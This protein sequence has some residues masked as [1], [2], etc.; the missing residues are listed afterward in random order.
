MPSKSEW[1]RCRPWIE[2]AL[3][4]QAKR[5]GFKTHEI[6]D[7]E[8]QI[9]REQAQL[10]A[11]QQS[12]A[13]TEIIAHPQATVLHLWLC[14]GRWADLERHLDEVLA[15]GRAQGCE[16]ATTA[17][18]KGWSRVMEKHGFA[19]VADVCGRTI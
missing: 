3:A 16:W 8:A 7:V 1:E 14:G 4:N 10:W 2:A 17:G 13:V 19:P 5:T 15:W 9:E 18:R 6:E 12:A 11:F